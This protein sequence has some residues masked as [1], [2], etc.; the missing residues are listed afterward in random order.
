MRVELTT[1]GLRNRCSATELRWHNYED[2]CSDKYNGLPDVGQSIF[3]LI[4][5]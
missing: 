5:H 3:N 1:D 2:M 4:D